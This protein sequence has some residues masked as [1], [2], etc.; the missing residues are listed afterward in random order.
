MN[1]GLVYATLGYII[2]GL[3]P[4]YWKALGQVSSLEILCH[5]MIWS[6]L[7]LLIILTLKKKQIL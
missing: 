6:V 2:W 5:R 1:Q 4:V 7:F 3:L